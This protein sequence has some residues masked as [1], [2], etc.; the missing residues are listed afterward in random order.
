MHGSIWLF[1]L[2]FLFKCVGQ[3]NFKSGVVEYLQWAVEVGCK[4]LETWN[5]LHDLCSGAES[6]FQNRLL[7]TTVIRSHQD[8]V[9]WDFIFQGRAGYVSQGSNVAQD[10]AQLPLFSNISDSKLTNTT[11]FSRKN[12]AQR[13]CGFIYC[14]LASLALLQP[15]LLKLNKSSLFSCRVHQTAGQL[16]EVYRRGWSGH[17]TRAWGD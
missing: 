3:A 8:I 2:F 4:S 11:T 6:C 5:R 7:T 1:S 13:R 16:W 10:H 14:V 9:L 12:V 15:S 17:C